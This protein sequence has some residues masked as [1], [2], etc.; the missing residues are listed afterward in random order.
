MAS[1]LKSVLVPYSAEQMFEV[2]AG[3]EDY[4][5][6]LPWCA[7][8]AVVE[9]GSVETLVR[10]DINY[11]GVRAH[12]TTANRNE[13]PERIVI[14]LHAGPF[15]HLNGTWRFRP[16]G[17][18][19]SKVEVELHYEFATAVLERL[20]GPVFGHIAHTLMDA[21]VRRAEDVYGSA[22]PADGSTGAR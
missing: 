12:F 3:V 22:A 19:G 7:G 14:E 4:P 16:L 21:F 20:I 2:V 15:R 10:L 17:A 6:F 18:N 9:Q 11:H 8:A 13:R 5:K 1:V